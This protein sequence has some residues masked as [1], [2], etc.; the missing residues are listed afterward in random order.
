MNGRIVLGAAVA[1]VLAACAALEPGTQLQPGMAEAQV[2]QVMGR[3]TNRYPMPDGAMRLEYARGP[4]GRTTWMVDLDASG[5][6]VAAEQVLDMAHFLRVNEG[7]TREQLLR[8]I[9]RPGHRAGE[10][11]NRETWSWRYVTNDCLWF[12]VTLS[13]EGRTLGGG[14]FMPDPECDFRD[15]G[16][17]MMQPPAPPPGR[18]G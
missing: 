2:V 4:A 7:M 17:S 14:S 10:W 12:R 6:L 3:P 1:A 11:Q 15:F 13:A 16:R 5:K 18:R 9:G 8:F